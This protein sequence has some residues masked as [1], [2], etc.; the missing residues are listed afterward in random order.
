MKSYGIYPITDVL[1]RK[2]K[3]KHSGREKQAQIYSGKKGHN[4]DRVG[5]MQ[6]KIT[7]NCKKLGKGKEVFSIASRGNKT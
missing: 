5:E 7:G 4:E 1:I 3:K 6:P 2:K